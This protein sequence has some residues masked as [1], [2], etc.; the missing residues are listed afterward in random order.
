MTADE[1]GMRR[2]L[3]IA[4][5]SLSGLALGLPAVAS[6]ATPVSQSFTST[7]EQQFVVPPGV[8]SLQVMLVGGNGAPGSGGFPGG[9]GATMTATLAV[10]AGETLYAEVGGDGDQS[11]A[12]GRSMGGYGG[13]GN[14]G[15][16]RFFGSFPGGGGGGGASDVRTCSASSCTE[17]ASLASRLVVAAGGGG[18]GGAGFSHIGT[19]SG[20]SGGAAEISG[21]AGAMDSKSDAGGGGGR[22]GAASAGGLAGEHSQDCEPM[23]QVG[24]AAAGT[25][26]QGGVGG[27]GLGAESLGGGGGGGGGGGLFGGGGGGGGVGT[28]EEISQTDFILYSGGGGGG[29]GGASGIPASAVGV[30]SDALTPTTEG[31][32]PS[33][34]FTWTPSA[35]AA[36]T[37]PPSAVTAT[38]AILTGTVNPS[39]WQVLSCAF[40][41][42][43]APA[44]VATF[45]C[46]QQLDAG[47]TPLPVSATAAGLAPSTTYAVSLLATSVQGTGSGSPVTFSTSPASGPGAG[48]APAGTGGLGT[49]GALTVT[50][51]KLSPTRFHRGTRPATIAKAKPKKKAKALPTSTTISFALSQAA[52]VKLSFELAQ[53]GVLAGRKCGATSKTHRKGK[54]CTRYTALR[55]AVTLAGHAGT[56]KITFA[57]VLDDD[58]RL[59]PGTYRLSLGATASAGS[60]TAA[61]HPTFTLLG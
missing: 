12:N 17:A 2:G 5:A 30:S 50:N 9:T 56:D 6:A 15:Y 39:A 14:G 8:S 35:P 1:K 36:V 24:C 32:L 27:E 43:P 57:G 34:T 44:G 55:G 61:Q 37:G 41:I 48:D 26:G 31:A 42:S 46:A 58:A 53:P 16:R 51:L 4:F 49:A 40:A 54:H 25:S 11:V 47:I 10:S 22:H 60:A 23:S 33:V 59:A 29:G 20:G 21:G 45:P 52:T 18:G 28:L 38:T 13:G 19:P 3:R 7:G